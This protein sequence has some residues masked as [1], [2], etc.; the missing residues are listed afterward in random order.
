MK[1]NYKKQ[2][3][4]RGAPEPS[5]KPWLKLRGPQVP[6]LWLTADSTPRL[7]FSSNRATQQS[8]VRSSTRVGNTRHCRKSRSH[9]RG[10]ARDPSQAVP[11][12]GAYFSGPPMI[13]Q[14][15]RSRFACAPKWPDEPGLEEPGR[16]A[17][18]GT[19]LTLLSAGST[20]GARCR[21]RMFKLFGPKRDACACSAG[22]GGMVPV[23]FACR[24]DGSPQH[25]LYEASDVCPEPWVGWANHDRRDVDRRRLDARPSLKRP[26]FQGF[27]EPPPA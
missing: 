10:V 11:L 25:A 12:W 20:A 3:C 26:S 19:A 6:P 8:H 9:T 15:W 21:H 24:H 4:S 27:S 1:L 14:A 5:P 22:S 2:G 23:G 16:H 17:K 18:S 13:S 7:G